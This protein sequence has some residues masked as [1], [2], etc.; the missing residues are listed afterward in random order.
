M[1]FKKCQ[2]IRCSTS[3]GCECVLKRD[4]VPVLLSH[5]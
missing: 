4:R 3:A 2:I 5:S 1:K